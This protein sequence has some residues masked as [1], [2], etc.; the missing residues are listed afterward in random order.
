MLEA[1]I[2]AR[3]LRVEYHRRPGLKIHV[4]A[5]DVRVRV[6]NDVVRDAPR[7]RRGAH[8]VEAPREDAVHGLVLAVAAVDGVVADVEAEAHEAEALRA[9]QEDVR[10]ERH[11]LR[12]R[13]RP[14]ARREAQPEAGLRDHG[15]VCGFLEPAL[16]E[17]RVHATT[18]LAVEVGSGSERELDVLQT[19]TRGR[20]K[21][22]S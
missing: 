20:V 3:L 5:G 21:P 4:D 14:R 8:Q 22:E 13:E 10:G 1:V 18:E 11:H 7:V 17:I 15:S 9:P 16:L 6:V 12:E 19:E 2:E